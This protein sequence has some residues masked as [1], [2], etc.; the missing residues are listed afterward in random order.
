MFFI[1]HLVPCLEVS[2]AME[3]GSTPMLGHPN[4]AP[5]IGLCAYRVGCWRWKL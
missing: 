4:K 2:M 5:L 1:F 3:D